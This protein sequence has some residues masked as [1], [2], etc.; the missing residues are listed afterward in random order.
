MHLPIVVSPGIIED[1]ASWS[2]VLDPLG[3]PINLVE[4][5]GVTVEEIA[6]DLLA[7]APRRFIMFGH[8]LGGYVALQVALTAPERV[9]GLV[10]V[11]TSARPESMAAREARS[12]LIEAAG[13]DFDSVV[14]RLARAALARANR[15]S[16]SP[17][18]A[19]MMHDQG[20]DRFA[21]EQ[22]AAASRPEFASRLGKLSCPV[23]VVT[24]TEDAVIDPAASEELAQAIAG[25]CMVRLEG[26][27]HM[28]QFEQ[29]AA[30]CQSL[31]E[32]LQACVTKASHSR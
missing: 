24:G 1:A 32:W 29:P 19:A 23:L 28:P 30:L 12:A 4:N 5:R 20:R 9:A 27:G 14:Q 17:V 7:Q 13:A 22:A 15:P 18:V 10:L 11:S 16:L 2:A 3:Y 31:G 21:R 8:S 6:L 25:A 26:C